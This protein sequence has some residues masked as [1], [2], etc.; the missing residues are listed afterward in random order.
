MSIRDKYGIRTSRPTYE[1]GRIYP[2]NPEAHAKLR[3]FWLAQSQPAQRAR[4]PQIDEAPARQPGR[5]I[6]LTLEQIEEVLRRLHD[7][8]QLSAI[9]ADFGMSTMT[10]SL[11][12]REAGYTTKRRR[13]RRRAAVDG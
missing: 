10:L 12:L 5:R 1:G 9:A 2:V 3:A 13:G 7:D 6:T 8:E 4:A 11:R